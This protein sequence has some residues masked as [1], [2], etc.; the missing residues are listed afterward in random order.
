[1]AHVRSIFNQCAE[2]F[3]AILVEKLAYKTPELLFHL[4]RPYLVKN[5]E[6]LDLGCG[7]GLGAVLYRPFAKHLTGVDIS[8]KMLEK[9]DEKKLYNCLEVFD[10]LQPWAFP[11]KF[12]LI[13]SADVF[14]YFGSLDGII[15]S[16]AASLAPGGKIAFS[17]ERLKN[18]AKDYQLYPSGRYAHSKRYIQNCLGCHG[19]S[20]LQLETTQIRKQSGKPVKGF[21][22]VAQKSP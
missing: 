8:E 11:K 17:T 2:N 3:E 13:Y 9:A 12:D 16:A 5:M 20:Q 4:V 18:D 21:L 15:K 19:L 10:I 22:V 6:I 1:M 14:V 7:T